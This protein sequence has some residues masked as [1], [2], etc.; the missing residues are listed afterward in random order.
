MSDNKYTFTVGQRVAFDVVGNDKSPFGYGVVTRAS[1]FATMVQPEGNL[2]PRLVMTN[3]RPVEA[4]D[5]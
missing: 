3:I 2:S 1:S 5:Q 4:Q